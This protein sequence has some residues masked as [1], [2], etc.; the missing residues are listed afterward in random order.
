L[1]DLVKRADG[2]I[3]E[4]AI[5]DGANVNARDE[6]RWT[7]LHYACCANPLYVIEMMLE[8]GADPF[9]Y[10]GQLPRPAG[11]WASPDVEKMTPRDVAVQHNR[12][13]ILEFFDKWQQRAGHAAKVPEPK[14]AHAEDA[15]AR[16]SERG[17]RKLGN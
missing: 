16:K 7:P 11:Q 15:A 1:F 9:A 2:P 6:K 17:P 3:V 14:T 12:T 10:A 5:R 8:K 4:A 13:D